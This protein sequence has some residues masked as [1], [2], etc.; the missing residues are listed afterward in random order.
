M[1]ETTAKEK[2]LKKV[3]TALIHKTDQPFPHV[4]TQKSVYPL[5][6]ESLDVVFA[7]ELTKAQG[8]F[9][10]CENGAEFV[11]N[12][13]ALTSTKKWNHLYC[14]DNSLQEIFIRY[15]FRN[16]RIGKSIEKADVGITRCEALIARTGTVLIS[17]KLASGRTLSIFPPV[18]VVVATT[19]QLVF[20]ISD[21]LEV[22]SSKYQD[23]M[24]SMISL[25]TGPSRTADIEKTLVLGAHGPK[26]VYV[27]L[28]DQLTK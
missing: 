11:E 23:D 20:D 17:S 15:D 9:V 18:H 8:N 2:I 21:G 27:F 1:K 22:V 16:S 13:K 12:L 25:I 28:I 24:P 10:Y 26:E 14:W 19:D 6:T 5:P 3:R 4:D 7:Q